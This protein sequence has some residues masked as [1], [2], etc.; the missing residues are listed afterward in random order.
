LWNPWDKDIDLG[1]WS[2]GEDV[3][4]IASACRELR[5][6]VFEMCFSDQESY[7]SILEKNYKITVTFYH[8]NNDKA[9]CTGLV[10]D[11]ILGQIIDY[12]LWVLK[13]RDAELKESRMPLSI[14]KKLVKFSCA[15]PN[16]LR[17]KF[18]KILRVLYEKI[19]SGRVNFAI[20]GHYFTSLSIIDFYGMKFK[21]PAETEEYLAYRYGKD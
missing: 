5:D 12:L 10:H 13:L 3:D 11:K 1:A 16:W 6:K 8:L 14:T 18:T 9:T 20:P 4:K 15:L 21:V 7:L 19:G 17:M 2:K